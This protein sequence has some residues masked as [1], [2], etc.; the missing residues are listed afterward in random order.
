MGLSDTAVEG[1]LLALD[2]DSATLIPH[3]MTRVTKFWLAST[4]GVGCFASNNYRDILK[5]IAKST[6]TEITVPDDL[7]GIQVSGPCM[8]DVDDAMAKLSEVEKPLVSEFSC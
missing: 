2:D 7:K 3:Q 5:D 6:G 8:D 1:G 4:G